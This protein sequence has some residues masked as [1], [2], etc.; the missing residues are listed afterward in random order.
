MKIPR[1]LKKKYIKTF[2]RGTYKAIIDGYLMVERYDKNK[3]IIVKYTN[4]QLIYPIYDGQY[5][6]FYTLKL[7]K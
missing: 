4:K 3:G 5:N 6:P 7:I 1:K 2:G